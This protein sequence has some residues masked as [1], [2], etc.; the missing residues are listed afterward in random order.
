MGSVDFAALQEYIDKISTAPGLNGKRLS[1]TT[2]KKEIA[3]LGITWNWGLNHELIDRPLSKKGLR[4]PQVHDRPPFQTMS[5]IERKIAAGGLSQQEI[6]E[7]W[8]SAFLTVVEIDQL[9]KL[10]RKRA[11]HRF[12]YP[13]L[14]FAAH[15]G[16]RR[17]EMRRSKLDDLDFSRKRVFIRERK[18]V[19]GRHTLRSVPMSPLLERVMR[20]WIAEHPG[21][22]STFV[23]PPGV[24]KSSK[25]R[26]KPTELTDDEAGHYF[27]QILRGTKWAKLRGWHVFRHSFCSN[28]A[29]QGVDQRMINTWVGHQT[30]A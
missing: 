16:A 3:T 12:L 23:L 22:R 1:A 28:T 15:T 10:V 4:Y 27:E 26:G 5:E 25:D 13:M 30:D 11:T 17:S 9:L 18:R 19:R 2:I 29:A 21:G 7:L 20:D 6:A 14:V 24:L 8:D